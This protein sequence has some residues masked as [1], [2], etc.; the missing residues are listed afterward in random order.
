[1]NVFVFLDAAEFNYTINYEELIYFN[2]R[3]W[4]RMNSAVLK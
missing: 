3:L 4:A 1:M 2:Y